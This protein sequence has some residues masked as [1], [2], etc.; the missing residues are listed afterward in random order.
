MARAPEKSPQSRNREHT[1]DHNH[2]YAAFGRARAIRTAARGLLALVTTL[3]VGVLPAGVAHAT[4]SVDEIER[5]IDLKWQQLEPVIEEYNKVR[6]QLKVNKKKQEELEKKIRPLSLQA[7][8]ASFRIGQMA[9]QFYRTGPTSD[10]NA[11]LTNGSASALTEQL[12]LLN[13][14]SRQEKAQIASVTAIR[15]KYAQEKQKLD[16]LVAKQQK[17]EAELAEKRKKID[18]EIKQLQQM[19]IQAYGS[20]TSGGTLRIGP[21]PP[22]YPG[23]KAGIAVKT[24]CAQ[25]GK[26]YVWGATGPNAF[27][28][29]GLTQ[30]AWAA[31]G[32]YL[33]HYTGAQ[34]NEGTPV[35]RSEAR[36]GDLVFFRA[37]LSHVGIYVGNNLMV[38]APTTG[39]VVRMASIDSM[40]IAGFRRPG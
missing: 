14:L 3:T 16:E 10:L 31:A 38:H 4:P 20:T 34:W 13:R 12:T 25:I 19:R 39:D 24:A 8:M 18:A 1:Q 21:C 40:P 22:I 6:S 17:Q 26:P 27:D 5:Q 29:S 30:Y 15:D 37:D 35:S 9:N 32:V 11:L 7:E 33:T 28:C 23:G 2:R 36:P